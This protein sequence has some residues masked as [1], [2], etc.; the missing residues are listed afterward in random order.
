LYEETQLSP[1]QTKIL[2][3]LTKSKNGSL[4]TDE[5]L[6]ITGIATSTW[7]A[8]QGKLVTM[9]LIN[10]HLV[11]IIEN[12]HI[13]KRMNYGLTEKGR[14]IG[15]NLLNISKILLDEEVK[16]AAEGSRLEPK[17]DRTNGS[18]VNVREI[19]D[20][21]SKVGECV[22]IALD[23]FG[24]N[25]VNLVKNS[26]EVEYKIPWVDLSQKPEVFESLL[27]DYFGMGASEKL[28]KLIA[29]NLKSRFDLGSYRSE[30]LSQLI[31]EARKTSLQTMQLNTENEEVSSPRMEA[32]R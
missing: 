18:G 20:F 5:V 32:E 27:K 2:V 10:K 26:L 31:S 4:R 14:M 30:N 3:A 21:S 22:E 29:A 6:G 7:S 15:L 13:S 23:S 9:G 12:N 17:G 1:V 19:E 16:A 28:K 25:L 11:R 8:E 24:S